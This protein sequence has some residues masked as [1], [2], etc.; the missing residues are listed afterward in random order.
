MRCDLLEYVVKS[1]RVAPQLMLVTTEITNC[2]NFEIVS[3]AQQ[4]YENVDILS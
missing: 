1:A 4:D 2:V 3:I